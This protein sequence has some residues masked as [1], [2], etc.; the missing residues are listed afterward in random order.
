MQLTK[1]T[2][3]FFPNIW[4][5][6]WS[7]KDVLNCF[8]YLW[9]FQ[10]PGRK[11]G[12]FGDLEIGTPWWKN[13]GKPLF[14][15]LV[16]KLCVF[17]FWNALNRRFSFPESLKFSRTSPHKNARA[18]NFKRMIRTCGNYTCLVANHLPCAS[19]EDQT[20]WSSLFFECQKRRSWLKKQC[21]TGQAEQ[22][23]WWPIQFNKGSLRRLCVSE[24]TGPFRTPT[25]QFSK[26]PVNWFDVYDLHIS[27]FF[28]F[29]LLFCFFFLQN[30]LRILFCDRI[31]LDVVISTGSVFGVSFCAVLLF[32]FCALHVD[33]V[34]VFGQTR[35]LCCTA[36]VNS[37]TSARIPIDA[38][39]ATFE[40][41]L[42]LP[43][44]LAS[45]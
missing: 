1:W 28:V 21:F 20:L 27:F 29:P 14:S 43:T 7:F 45:T 3:S 40:G 8:S 6:V 32:L 15:A 19:N 44:F 35:C 37:R 42:T 2:L 24:D 38:D 23:S 17:G 16:K 30:V 11:S 25:L 12:L 33:V 4:N 31:F 22:F 9:F 13:A 26:Y 5:I 10:N 18:Y 34:A 39:L 41:A 36:L